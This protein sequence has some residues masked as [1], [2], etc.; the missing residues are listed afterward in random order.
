MPASQAKH[1]SVDLELAPRGTPASCRFCSMQANLLWLCLITLNSREI[2]VCQLSRLTRSVSLPFL[3]REG[4]KQRVNHP[5]CCVI[6]FI[7]E[8]ASSTGDCLSLLAVQQKPRQGTFFLKID[9]LNPSC[10]EQAVIVHHKGRISTEVSRYRMVAIIS[11]KYTFK[12]TQSRHTHAHAPSCC[13]N[14]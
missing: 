9:L 1:R 3:E 6:S 8:Q 13:A 14:F 10:A 5:L 4:L 7:T 12:K 2:S 11:L